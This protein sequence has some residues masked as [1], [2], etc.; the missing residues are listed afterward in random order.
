MAPPSLTQ[1]T[2][3][4]L[5]WNYAGIVAKQ[6]CTF[7]IGIVL[8][9]LLGPAPFGIV[10]IAMLLCGFAS[11]IADFGFSAALI[12]R[13][14][15]AEQDIRF[16]FT[17]QLL[18]AVL[19]TGATV[20][21]AP[22]FASI[23]RQ[24]DAM[25]VIRVLSVVFVIQAVGQVSGALLKRE[26][27]FRDLQSAQI[28]SYLVAYC[29]LGIPLAAAGWGV[30]SLVVAQVAQAAIRSAWQYA[31]ARHT[32]R[33]SLRPSDHGLSA[34][35]GKVIAANIA[36]WSITNVD[37]AF[38]ARFFSTVDLGF[39]SR[40][41]VLVMTPVEAVVTTLQQ[42]LFPAYS[43]THERD[44]AVNA[45]YLASLS[46]VLLLVAPAALV[47]AA[48]PHTVVTGLLGYEWM[49]AVVLVVPLALAA[50]FHAAMAMAG[51]LLWGRDAVGRELTVQALA[52][53]LAV[54]AFFGAAQ[55][56]L[57]LLAWAVGA[58]YVIRSALMTATLILKQRVPVRSVFRASSQP[59]SLGLLIALGAFALDR[60]LIELR[61]D[62]PTRLVTLSVVSLVAWV[63][64]LTLA[65]TLFASPFLRESLSRVRREFPTVFRPFVDHIAARA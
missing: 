58:L 60:V 24:P 30:W 52:A 63:G 45:T 49:P 23:F 34:F 44:E 10:A 53:V 31:R 12:Q 6:V 11:L 9:R 27:R 59:F 55:Y 37:N 21:T 22:L 64:L 39:Y 35:G 29:A 38:V 7:A 8:A 14:T 41:Y 61:T 40:M 56:S 13:K 3:S 54:G 26:L 4:G 19:L 18:M 36:N 20:A 33:F 28:G 17:A 16:A 25:P 1:A 62:A 5:K 47:V 51:P 42:V 15:L 50:P 65:P 2:V 57:S 48:I 43:R 32:V 46:A